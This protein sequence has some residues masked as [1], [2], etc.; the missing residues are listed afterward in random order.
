MGDAAS[1]WARSIVC[2]PVEGDAADDTPVEISGKHGRAAASFGRAPNNLNA[3]VHWCQ[4]VKFRAVVP[5]RRRREG[6]NR[7]ACRWAS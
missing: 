1:I 3:F 2:A 6:R 5:Q 4:Y 7:N